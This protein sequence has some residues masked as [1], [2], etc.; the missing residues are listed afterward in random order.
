MA[1]EDDFTLSCEQTMQYTDHVSLKCTLEIYM[2]LLTNVTA[3]YL[4][5]YVRNIC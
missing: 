5:I 3:I 2:N 4:K 1:M